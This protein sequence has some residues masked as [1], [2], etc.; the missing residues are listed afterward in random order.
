MMNL[1]WEFWWVMTGLGRMKVRNSSDYGSHEDSS[2]Y[3][4]HGDSSGYGSPVD[5]SPFP[6]NLYLIS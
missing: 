2:D 1:L 3:G 4:S 6:L 5:S